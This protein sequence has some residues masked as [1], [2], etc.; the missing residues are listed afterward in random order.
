[1]CYNFFMKRFF[2]EKDKVSNNDFTIKDSEHNYLANVLRSKVGEDVTVFCGDEYDYICTIS[3]IGKKDSKLQL[4]EKIVNH[5]NPKVV[6]DIFQGLPKSEKL[7]LITQKAN[8]LG[9]SNIYTF[10]SEFA[11]AKKNDNKTQRMNKIAIE[12]SKQC[13]RSDYV[14]VHDAIKFHD[15]INKLA[16]YD[17]VIFAYEKA[18]SEISKLNFFGKI[19]IVIGSEGGFSESEVTLMKEKGFT[20]IKISNRILRTETASIASL[21]YVAFSLGDSL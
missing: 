18:Q 6:I 5:K 19:A 13:G 20:P 10:E 1:M 11:T 3:Y 14:K 9:A 2:I 7:E 12:S 8:E 15:L 16:D 21:A 17:T 4:R